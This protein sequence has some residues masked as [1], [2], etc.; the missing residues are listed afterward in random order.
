MR[1]KQGTDFVSLLYAKQLLMQKE[2]NIDTQFLGRP[3]GRFQDGGSKIKYFAISNKICDKKTTLILNREY[4]KL[5]SAKNILGDFCYVQFF[6]C[7]FL[8]AEVNRKI[9]S[10]IEFSG[11]RDQVT[12]RVY[13]QNK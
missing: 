6:Y 5:P 3:E 2:I 10:D 4:K 8:A 1:T 9:E 12:M 7:T 13:S 11:C